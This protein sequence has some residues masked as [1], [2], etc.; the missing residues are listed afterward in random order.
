MIGR[1][2]ISEGTFDSRGK[3]RKSFARLFRRAIG[4]G[5]KAGKKKKGKSVLSLFLFRPLPK[6]ERNGIAADVMPRKNITVKDRGM[7]FSV[8]RAR[9]FCKNGGDKNRYRGKIGARSFVVRSKF[10]CVS[11]AKRFA[12][13]EKGQSVLRG[14]RSNGLSSALYGFFSSKGE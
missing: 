11:S 5:Q 9:G 10:S 8:L 3:G 1:G 2:Q 13:E 4:R 6:R 12:E 7:A 14:M